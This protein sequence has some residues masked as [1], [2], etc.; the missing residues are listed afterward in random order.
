MPY[1]TADRADVAF[2]EEHGWIVV[3]DAV[4]PADLATLEA[5]CEVILEKKESMAFDWA[6]EEGTPKEERAFKIVQSSPT[7]FFPELNDDAVPHVG[8]RVR[9]RR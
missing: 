8:G 9:G 3:A 2:F 5:A 7:L 4:D 6:W 1:P